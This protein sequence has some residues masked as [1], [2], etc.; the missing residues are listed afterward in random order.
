M[1]TRVVV[2]R[3][4]G[5]V[6]LEECEIRPGDNE[7]LVKTYMSS[8]C[9]TDKNYSQ[10]MMPR[11]V[12][13]EQLAGNNEAHHA[14]PLKMGHEAAGEIV[15]VGRNVTDFK[16]GDKVMSFGWYNTMADYFVAPVVHNGFGVVKVPEGMSMEVASLGEPTA[17]AVYAGMNSGVELG[18]TV[19]IVGVGFAGQVMAQVI[20]R[21]GA[22][23]VIC[24]DVVDG[25]LDLA[26][27]MG[28]DIVLNPERDDVAEVVM[29]ETNRQGADVVIEA[30][31]ND[32]AIQLCS[33]VLKH[34]GILGLYSW[35]LEPATLFINRWHNDGF[36]IR[37]LALMHRIKMDRPW[38]I[39][40][41]LQN[42]AN[43]M[44]RIDPLIS[45]VFDLSEAAEAFEA[46][47]NDPAAC[48]VVLK[49]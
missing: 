8:I 7:V 19:V 25:K 45:H 32:A 15:E 2:T 49:S 29:R 16:V 47:C 39:G 38:W 1:K 13:V 22:A 10:G 17:C 48:K 46:A 41:T 24:V 26:K 43:G 14:Y 36:D 11:E 4:P 44:I 35:V 21:M 40:K 23:K 37:T 20:K 5:E 12:L 27:R 6:V 33:D 18:D 30:A 31:G 28:A 9:G 34:G 3:R 42:V